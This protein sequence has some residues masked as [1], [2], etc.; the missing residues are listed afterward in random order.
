MVAGTSA[1]LMTACQWHKWAGPR[2]LKRGS[3]VLKAETDLS[4]GEQ[5][6]IDR[7]WKSFRKLL[8]VFKLFYCQDLGNADA[9]SAFYK[10]AL[11]AMDRCF[12]G[13]PSPTF[14]IDRCTVAWPYLQFNK[15]FPNSVHTRAILC[16]CDFTVIIQVNFLIVPSHPL[17]KVRPRPPPVDG[18]EDDYVDFGSPS[19]SSFVF[20][21][22]SE[23]E[24]L[25]VRGRM[26]TR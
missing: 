1:R 7:A 2:V 13:G 26:L 25:F 17:D 3:E 5:W 23:M 24:S 20:V 22:V 21:W 16:K 12:D 10:F 8:W 18:D 9:T 6:F 19:S 14:G 15:L 4:P 11:D